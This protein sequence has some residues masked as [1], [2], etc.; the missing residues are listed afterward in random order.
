MKL[1]SIII[2]FILTLVPELEL[3]H[4]QSLK[5]HSILKSF[6]LSN[7][8]IHSALRSS[9]SAPKHITGSGTSI[10]PYVLY[11]A[12]D[13]DSIRHLGTNNKYYELANDIDLSSIS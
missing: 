11:D 10:D 6:N 3:A 9:R 7:F 5:N 1:L 2:F 13:V 12:Q 8:G 4:A